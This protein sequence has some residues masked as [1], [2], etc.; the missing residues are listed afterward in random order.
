VGRRRLAP[1]AEESAKRARAE[2]RDLGLDLGLSD[3]SGIVPVG[4]RR[5]G[6]VALLGRG[7]IYEPIR[8]FP[9]K[10]VKW[11]FEVPGRFR[12]LLELAT[13]SLLT[14]VV[15]ETLRAVDPNLV[16]ASTYRGR[17]EDMVYEAALRAPGR[18]RRRVW[19]R[20]LLAHQSAPDGWLSGR[21]LDAVL[22][23]WEREKREQEGARRAPRRIRLRPIV[24]VV[25][26]TGPR[27][28][29]PPA[30]RTRLAGL[31]DPG[32]G[33]AAATPELTLH[34][35]DLPG[36]PEETLLETG[37]EVGPVLALYRA[38]YRGRVAFER[39]LGR[40]VAR[41]VAVLEDSEL[42]QQLLFF[43]V[44]LVGHRR[45]PAEQVT[46]REIVARAAGRGEV[47]A[48][49]ESW[50]QQQERLAEERA[51]ERA[52]EAAAEATRASVLA[53]LRKR[54]GDVNAAVAAA[55]GAVEDVDVLRRLHE[56]AVV[57]ASVADFERLV[58]EVAASA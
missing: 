35:V 56:E 29:T 30:W 27:P 6:S 38:Q 13:P 3:R 2:A 20:V 25:L 36:L 32:L 18:G 17:R 22:Q 5:S 50:A 10:G 55:V 42:R 33:G 39:T 52:A 34:T 58:R 1:P 15:P 9:D 16:S 21:L 4:G 23:L 44:Q 43:C 7:V 48:M 11:L 8:D 45:P 57:V 31:E 19:F 40:V 28:W 41:L 12:Q 54:F 46:L 24:V 26:H 37:G 51:E 49:V 14:R 53:V 47:E